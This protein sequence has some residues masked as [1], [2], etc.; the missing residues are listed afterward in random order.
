MERPSRAS[1]PAAMVVGG[2]AFAYLLAF[3]PTL[4]VSDEALFLYGAKRILSGQALYRDFFEFITPA[5]FYFFALVYAVAGT[6]LQAARAAMAAV[7]GLSAALV[8]VLARKV[9]RVPEALLAAVVFTGACLP[10]WNVVSP[11]WL[12][13]AACLATAAVVLSDRLAPLGRLRPLLAGAV[14]GLGFS[15]QQQRGVLLGVWLA[16]ALAC[17][18]GPGRGVKR[19]LGALAWAALGWSGVVGAIVGY[20]VSRSSAAEVVHAVYTHVV[21]VYGPTFVGLAGWGVTA[22]WLARGLV[23]YTWPW[24]PWLVPVVLGLEAV[25]LA[26]AVRRRVAPFPAA[27]GRRMALWF[28]A[29]C[30]VTA[31]AYFPD[32]I[33][34]AFI[35]PFSLVVAAGLVSRARS[36]PARGPVPVVG[37]AVVTVAIGIAL[38]KS[39]T[40]LALRRSQ[41]PVRY[42]TAFG[43]VAGTE[44]TRASWQ[45]VHDAVAAVPAERRTLF[46]Y[47]NNA[48][49]YLTLPGENPTPY[50]LLVVGYNTPEQIRTAVDA[51]TRR[52][53]DYIIVSVMLAHGGDPMMNFIASRYG[54]QAPGS[55]TLWAV[56][57]PLP[58]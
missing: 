37:A 21:S 1:L 33:H 58:R 22:T 30:M 44:M 18:S 10:V 52:P 46:S 56:Y 11:H 45:T 27:T 25:A 24:L 49:F 26:A 12:V 57:I 2:A 28:L 4:N 5:G 41:L 29:V 55:A 54:P 31:V 42:E 38:H 43:T 39:G 32:L 34:V 53:P 50:S 19:W 35:L 16:V 51:L 17:L 9:A 23:D 3:P 20:A 15:I 14:A 13:T 6:T 7:N 36:G 8:Y 47:P 48:S 40:T